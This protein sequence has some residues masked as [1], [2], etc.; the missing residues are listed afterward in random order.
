[1]DDCPTHDDL[2]RVDSA[3]SLAEK[4][5]LQ[6]LKPCINLFTTDCFDTIR[7]CA[8]DRVHMYACEVISLCLLYSEFKDSIREGDGDRVLRCWKFFLPIFKVDRKSNY[9]IEAVTFIAEGSFLFPPRLRQQL[10]WSRFINTSGKCGGNIPHMEHLNRTVKEALGHEFSNLHTQAIVRT[11]K[12]C[13]LLD[14]AFD[15]E[16]GV[17]T[18]STQH[19]AAAL[20]NDLQK[21]VNQL[22]SLQ[23]FTQKP[24]RCHSKFRNLDNTITTPLHTMKYAVS[25]SHVLQIRF[26]IHAYKLTQKCMFDRILVSST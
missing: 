16:S 19:T 23:V 1:M 25:N 12:I 8:A 15:K 2:Q 21:I 11:G 26:F 13:G 17:R 6:M 3:S 14:A 20:A 9:A 24:G 4:Q 5:H 18:R 10:L 22:V 7:V